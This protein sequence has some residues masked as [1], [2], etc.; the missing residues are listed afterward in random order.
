MFKNLKQFIPFIIIA[1]TFYSCLNEPEIDPAKVPFTTVRVA[2]FTNSAFKLVIDGVVKSNSL[3]AE[4]VTDYFD[5]TSGTR[6]YVLLDAN[7]DTIYSRPITTISYEE[8]TIVFVGYVNPTNVKENTVKFKSYTDGKTYLNDGVSKESGETGVIFVNAVNLAPTD[9]LTASVNVGVEYGDT[10]FTKTLAAVL[11][12]TSIGVPV[13]TVKIIPSLTD[14]AAVNDTLNFD[15]KAGK[16]N[17]VFLHGD[18]TNIKAVTN[19][20]VPQAARAK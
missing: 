15:F 7:G 12:K 6:K 11:D 9:T 10:I 14:K 17:Y 8:A 1:L 20:V 2:N 16:R 13:G 5:L 3:A 18:L 19:E 4:G